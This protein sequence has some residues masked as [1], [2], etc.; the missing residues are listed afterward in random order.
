GLERGQSLRHELTDAAQPHDADGLA[1]QLDAVEG[2]ALPGVLAQGRVRG[3][4]LAAG[5]HEQCDGVLGRR[6]DVG[7]G[8]VDHH[9]APLGGGGNLDVVKSDAG[10]TDDLEVRRGGEHLGVDGGGG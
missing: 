5:G 2:A 4:D 7:G 10:A 1:E 9:D 6:V 8:R 3:R